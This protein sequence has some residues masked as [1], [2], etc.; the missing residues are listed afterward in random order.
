MDQHGLDTD[1]RAGQ[2]LMLVQFVPVSSTRES[3][4]LDV[5]NQTPQPVVYALSIEL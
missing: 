5:P 3:W 4:I 1:L 2:D